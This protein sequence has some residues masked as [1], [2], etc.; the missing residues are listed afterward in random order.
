MA[1]DILKTEHGAEPDGHGNLA[2]FRKGADLEG[3][4]GGCGFVFETP[5]AK[6]DKQRGMRGSH[7]TRQAPAAAQEPRGAAF[8]LAFGSG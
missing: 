7:P 5:N 1:A 4:R 6:W 2:P 3:N 8:L